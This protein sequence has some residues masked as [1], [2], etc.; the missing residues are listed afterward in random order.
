MKTIQWTVLARVIIQQNYSQETFYFTE[1]S[2]HYECSDICVGWL[3][4]SSNIMLV[5]DCMIYFFF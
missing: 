4:V 3:S 1:C 5:L 2:V